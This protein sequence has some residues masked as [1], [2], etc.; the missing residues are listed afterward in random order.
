MFVLTRVSEVNRACPQTDWFF[1][2]HKDDE[3]IVHE[4]GTVSTLDEG[5]V[6]PNLCSFHVVEADCINRFGCFFGCGIW[7]PILDYLST[8]I[9]L[10]DV[11]FH[12]SPK[13]PFAMSDYLHVYT[14]FNS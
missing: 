13:C 11:S 3:L 12:S 1:I 6:M 8:F 10:Y 2:L 7:D 9:F 5:I 4:A 14:P